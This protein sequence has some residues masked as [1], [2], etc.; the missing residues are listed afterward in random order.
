MFGLANTLYR[1][2]TM[3]VRLVAAV[4]AEDDVV[5]YICIHWIQLTKPEANS[6]KTQNLLDFAI[7][8]T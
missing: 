2:Y 6:L 8:D 1:S 4:D 3:D 5:C 7:P